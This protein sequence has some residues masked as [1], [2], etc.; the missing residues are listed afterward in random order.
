MASNVVASTSPPRGN[1]IRKGVRFWKVR[2]AS[3]NIGSLTSKSI[4]LV[5]SLHRR[6][7]N[8][9]CVQEIKWVGAKV[10]EIDR[11]KQWYS[12][13]KKTRNGVGI[14]VDKE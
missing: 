7:I 3:W 11:Y 1:G 8:I 14:L 6:R 10:R 13:P 9:A 5:T 4:E 12:R 2:L